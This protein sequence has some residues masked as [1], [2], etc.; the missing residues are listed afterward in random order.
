MRSVNKVA[1]VLVAIASTVAVVQAA[2]WAMTD[3]STFVMEPDY[4]VPE[5]AIRLTPMAASVGIIVVLVR[6]GPV[7][8]AGRKF[9]T[10]LR[11]LIIAALV[12]YLV[13]DTALAIFGVDVGELWQDHGGSFPWWFIVPAVLINGVGMIAPAVLG[14]TMFAQGDRSPAAWLLSAAVAV[15][16]VTYLGLAA[17]GGRWV[18]TTYAVV[19]MNFGLAL[20]GAD[21]PREAPHHEPRAVTK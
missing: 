20:L 21:Q 3:P 4:P 17:F 16:A 14:I 15:Y 8:D 13:F 12:A 1:V 6:N 19:V 11:L 9:R 10:V 18:D 5:W 2:T 7:I